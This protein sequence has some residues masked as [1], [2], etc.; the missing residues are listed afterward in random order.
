M[1]H[2]LAFHNLEGIIN[3]FNYFLIGFNFDILVMDM[4]KPS[5]SLVPF[6]KIYELVAILPKFYY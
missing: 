2:G 6:D 5:L 1:L 4:L 3:K